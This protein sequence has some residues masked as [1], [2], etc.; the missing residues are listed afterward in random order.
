MQ[1]LTKLKYNISFHRN[2]LTSTLL[3]AKVNDIKKCNNSDYHHRLF[4]NPYS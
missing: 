3:S 1:D 2:L 4:K